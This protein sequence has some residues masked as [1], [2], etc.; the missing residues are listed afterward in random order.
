M[1]DSNFIKAFIIICYTLPFVSCKTF[2]NNTFSVTNLD[3]TIKAKKIS[4]SE[5]AKYYKSYHGQYIETTGRFHEGFEEFAIYTNKNVLTGEADAFWL[6]YD[7]KLNIDNA[8]FDKMNGKIVTIKGRLDT[9]HKGHLSGYLATIG[10]IHF[11][12]Y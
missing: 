5:L 7:E 10:E 1:R 8:S 6:S 3:T 9:L 12:Q 4:I 2:P 11:W